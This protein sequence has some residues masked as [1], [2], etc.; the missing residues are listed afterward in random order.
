MT[1]AYTFTPA[2]PGP[3]IS[4][5]APSLPGAAGVVA[6]QQTAINPNDTYTATGSIY[7]EL[8]R[9]FLVLAGTLLK[10]EYSN[11]SLATDYSLATYSVR[12]GAWFS[13]LFYGYAS[14][15][16][17][18]V[19][20]AVGPG[21]TYSQLTA[22]IGSGKIARFFSGS[23]YY[24]YQE[25]EVADGGGMAGG[26]IYGAKVLYVPTAVWNITL[27]VDHIINISNITAA[28]PN[29]TPQALPGIPLAG[30]PV[31]LNQSVEVTAPALRSDYRF[32]EQTSIFGA[33][34]Y[35]SVDYLNSTQFENFWTASV[36]IRHSLSDHLT[37][38][39]DYQYT[40]ALSNIPNTTFNR[41]YTA[42]GAIYK[43]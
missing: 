39:F 24:G 19:S 16:Q 34:G 15:A 42:V 31:G 10:T 8:N 2:L 7:K 28:L 14:G 3:I 27:S 22:G 4:A 1:N 13:P 36:G 12:G 32:S 11:Q 5:A 26:S 30:S 17:S 41:N 20:A 33:I 35:T 21:E 23:V 25:T 38:T 40:A 9:A 43:F 37:L 29:G 18:F 6:L